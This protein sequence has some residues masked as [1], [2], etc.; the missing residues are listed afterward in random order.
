MDIKIH[1]IKQSQ[2]TIK[3]LVIKGK[4]IGFWLSEIELLGLN[5]RDIQIYPIPGVKANSIFGCFVAFKKDYN[6]KDER[7][8][9]AFQLYNNRIYIPLNSTISPKL[10]GGELSQVFKCLTVFHPDFGFV[11]L[12]EEIVWKEVIRLPVKQMV[13]VV[14][15]IKPPYKPKSIKSF[16]LFVPVLNVEQIE[17]S[18]A[19]EP[20]AI[21]DKLSFKDK[22]KFK[23]LGLL[24]SARKNSDNSIEIK[25]RSWGSWISSSS[26]FQKEYSLLYKRNQKDIDKL[27]QLFKVNPK[28]AMRF[29]KQLDLNGSSRGLGNGSQKSFN[30]SVILGLF[31]LFCFILI[32]SASID[33]SSGRG[34]IGWVLV[35]IV[36]LFFRS[37]LSLVKPNGS[38]G[39]A[40]TD[41]TR[42]LAL[43][44]A[45]RKQAEDYKKQGEYKEAARIYLNLL[46][47]YYESAKALEEGKYYQEAAHIYIKYCQRNNEAALCYENGQLYSKALELYIKMQKQNDVGRMYQKLGDDQ[48]AFIHFKKDIDS[49]IEKGKYIQAATVYRDNLNDTNAFLNVLKEGWNKNIEASD[50][51]GLYFKHFKDEELC[52]EIKTFYKSEV[53]SENNGLFLKQLKKLK[54]INEELK[55]TSRKIAYDIVAD[56]IKSR[57]GAIHQL[58]YFNE[59]DADFKKDIIRFKNKK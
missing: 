39:Y 29:A 22:M 11:E 50:C 53:S 20:Q 42:L 49:K 23:A 15:I 17:E 16:K 34:F 47:N 45:Y 25:K 13:D 59:G 4:D 46:K 1:P 56:M 26:T 48:L 27:I 41:N 6:G 3:A 32:L 40:P 57:K 31:A 9:T 52:D 51:L 28:L 33:Q 36:L 43:Q 37:I 7:G 58:L 12:K 35:F 54:G 24:F 19:I 44:K 8:H 30:N 10:E 14:S 38:G 2:L 55:N 5:S 21:S 18:L